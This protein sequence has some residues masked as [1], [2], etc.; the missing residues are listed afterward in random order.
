MT[1]I[2][3][4]TVRASLIALLLLLGFAGFGVA[5]CDRQGP[6]E[7]VGEKI[8]NAVENTSDKIDDVADDVRDS[9]NN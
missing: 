5:G 7:K 6:A 3:M 1:T 4:T 2:N 9:I 8:D